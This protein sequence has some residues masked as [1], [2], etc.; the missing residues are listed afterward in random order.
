MGKKLSLKR[1]SMEEVS[2]LSI[3]L[4][5][6]K[7]LNNEIEKKK[8]NTLLSYQQSLKSYPMAGRTT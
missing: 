1:A 2:P 5:E 8:K 3:P 7:R 6:T 4:E